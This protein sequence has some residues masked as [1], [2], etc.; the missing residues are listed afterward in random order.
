MKKS[1]GILLYRIHNQRIEVLLGHMGG[2]FWA[3]KKNYSWTIFKGE[4]E[5]EEPLEAALREFQEETGHTIS[6]DHITFLM[7]LQ[8]NKN[9]QLFVFVKEQDKNTET[10]HSN[11][12]SM[13]FPKNSGIIKEYPEIDQY[14]WFPLETISESIVK[15]QYPI[16]ESL[17]E[18][19]SNRET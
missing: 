9:K 13:E 10:M 17:K 15:S 12:F 4:F 2:P 19:L 7:S 1:A 14:Q 3:K 11:L 5:E 16:I 6:A 18:M 8:L